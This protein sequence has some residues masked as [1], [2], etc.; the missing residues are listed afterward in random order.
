MWKW[1]LGVP[2][3]LFVLLMI[4]GSFSS[5]GG[6]SGSARRAI[7]HCWSEQSRKSLAPSEARFI[8]GACEK[9]ERDYKDKY[10]RA[11]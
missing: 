10:G 4:V 7:D 2:A 11:P 1:I 6:E 3:G 5:G 8:A 9:M